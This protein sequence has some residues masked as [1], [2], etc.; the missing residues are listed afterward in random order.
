MTNWGIFVNRSTRQRN[1]TGAGFWA[2]LQAGLLLGGVANAG[3]MKQMAD[4]NNQFYRDY[5]AMPDDAKPSEVAAL[6]KKDFGPA[7]TALNAERQQQYKN[8]RQAIRDS[9]KASAGE[10][11]KFLAHLKGPSGGSGGSG[12]GLAGGAGVA[13]QKREQN[14]ESEGAT[15]A[16]EVN[17]LKERKLENV[18]VNNDGIIMEK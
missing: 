5:K 15:G 3:A 6:A 14:V 9:S 7:M 12:D 17:I 10:F 8:W 13:G 16:K 18:K 11:A 2:V 4:A 1:S